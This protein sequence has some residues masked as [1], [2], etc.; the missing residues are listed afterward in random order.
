MVA[1]IKFASLRFKPR[2]SRYEERGMEWNADAHDVCSDRTGCF[3]SLACHWR[4]IPN[5]NE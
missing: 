2:C 3:H 1:T 5:C 4:R